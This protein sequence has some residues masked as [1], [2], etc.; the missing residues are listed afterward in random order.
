MAVVLFFFRTCVMNASLEPSNAL[1]P[2]VEL[3]IDGVVSLRICLLALMRLHP[4]ALYRPTTLA[5]LQQLLE[6]ILS[7][8]VTFTDSVASTPVPA[9]R[10]HHSSSSAA[11]VATE[12]SFGDFDGAHT[13]AS[14]LASLS[15]QV[16]LPTSILALRLANYVVSV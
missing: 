8:D 5:K 6:H 15:G 9:S 14:R 10:T 1:E 16:D 13:R 2:F 7:A 11:D 12:L 3:A 4:S